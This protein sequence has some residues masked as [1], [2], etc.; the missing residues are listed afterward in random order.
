MTD[1]LLSDMS[2]ERK[3]LLDQAY[4]ELLTFCRS[5]GLVFEVCLLLSLWSRISSDITEVTSC[6]GGGLML[7]DPWASMWRARST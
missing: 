3:A 6:S 4:P 7:G 2:S 1:H 5:L